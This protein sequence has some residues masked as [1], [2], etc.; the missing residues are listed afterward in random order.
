MAERKGPPETPA[1]GTS[2][3]GTTAPDSPPADEVFE[4]PVGIGEESGSPDTETA[5]QE[6]LDESGRTSIEEPL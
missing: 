6:S 4:N 5:S 1:Y 2:T 3:E